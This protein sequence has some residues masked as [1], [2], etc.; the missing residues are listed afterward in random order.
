LQWK[1]E[2]E[3]CTSSADKIMDA[4]QVCTCFQM[5]VYFGSSLGCAVKRK[6]AW[7][8]TFAMEYSPAA[9]LLAGWLKI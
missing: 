7:D 5:R 2:K 4:I 6:Y 3:N 1:E 8:I 9:I